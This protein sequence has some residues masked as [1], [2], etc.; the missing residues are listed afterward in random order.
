MRCHCMG[1]YDLKPLW[2]RIKRVVDVALSLTFEGKKTRVESIHHPESHGAYKKMPVKG[3][4]RAL[5]A[6]N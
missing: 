5:V 3:M 4:H 1:S 2:D 6:V